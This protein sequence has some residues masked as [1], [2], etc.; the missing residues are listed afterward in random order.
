MSPDK[1][2][3]LAAALRENLKKRKEQGRAQDKARASGD[4][5]NSVTLAQQG[6]ERDTLS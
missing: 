1:Q 4:G 5:Q 2:A 3:R 6:H